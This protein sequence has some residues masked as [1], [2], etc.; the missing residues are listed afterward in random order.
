MTM[1]AIKS[2]S[3]YD[4]KIL[5][6]KKDI[7]KRK[8]LLVLIYKHL[9]SIGLTDTAISLIDES[10]IN[11]SDYELADNIDLFIIL[12][13][14][15]NYF[16]IK[17]G[18]KPVIIKS[19]NKAS[20]SVNT[21]PKSS[22]TKSRKNKLPSL[23][24]NNGKNSNNNNTNNANGNNSTNNINTNTNQNNKI[25][26]LIK[27]IN[28]ENGNTNNNLKLEITNTTNTLVNNLSK[29]DNSESNNNVLQATFEERKESMLLKPLPDHFFSEE[30]K[31]MANVVRREIIIENINVGFA[32]IVGSESAKK[33]IN[34]AL[35]YPIK[36][37]DM[38]TGI[39]EPWKGILLYGPP[40]TGKVC[41]L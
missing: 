41:F 29:K 26:K 30:L 36:Y 39:L 27:D 6:E 12:T 31:E 2:R 16:D 10:N 23:I 21:N 5:L 25:Q 15:E 28:N 35:F 19:Y 24:N 17:F 13:E 3:E 32:D 7:E 20:G 33:L 9:I 4:N 14:F 38:F 8:N 22:L 37:P 34:E 11:I 1:N 18:K 40:G